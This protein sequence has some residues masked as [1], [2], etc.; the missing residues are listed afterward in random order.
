MFLFLL[1]LRYIALGLIPAGWWEKTQM[2][3]HGCEDVTGCNKSNCCGDA[4]GTNDFGGDYPMDYYAQDEGDWSSSY[5]K[6]SSRPA[7]KISVTCV[8]NSV[9]SLVVIDLPC[10]APNSRVIS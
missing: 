1:R 3:K 4:K 5:V 10:F 6:K 7:M 2:Q 9:I 8:A